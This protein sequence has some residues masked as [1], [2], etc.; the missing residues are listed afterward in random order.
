MFGYVIPNQQELKL[1]EYDYYRSFYCGFCQALKKKYGLLG[2]ATV[3][4]DM[5]FLILLL[6]DLY[7]EE[8]TDGLV[9]CI[10]HPFEKH[11]TRQ[12]KITEYAADMNLILSYYSCLD[13][14]NDEHKLHKLLLAKLLKKGEEGA[15]I[16]YGKKEALVKDRLD[17]LHQCESANDM[18]IDRVSGYFGDIMAE[19][20]A[21]YEDEWEDTLRRMGFFLGKFIYIMDAYEDL[22]K[23]VENHSYNPLIPLKDKEDFESYCKQ[24]M[25]M[26]LAQCCECFEALPCIDHVDIL[27]NILYSGV[28]TRYNVLQQKGKRKDT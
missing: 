9:K 22:E 13:D 4:Y 12:T 2:Q 17:K 25:T 15:A 20:F 18:D 1:K 28:W 7:D 6:S 3:S 21:I 5:T 27:R 16:N 14:W 24:I 10:A 8:E 19:L 26:M 23:D 11:P